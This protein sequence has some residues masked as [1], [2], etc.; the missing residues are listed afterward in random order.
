MP[1]LL[2]YRCQNPPPPHYPTALNLLVIFVAPVGTYSQINSRKSTPLGS[3]VFTQAECGICKTCHRVLVL[4]I[5]L[6]MIYVHY[7]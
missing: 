3:G 1:N 2:A 7:T 4:I 6:L 5:L